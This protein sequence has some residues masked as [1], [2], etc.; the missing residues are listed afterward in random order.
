MGSFAARMMSNPLFS[1]VYEHAWRPVF[2]RGFSL[3]GPET[4]DYDAALRAFLRRPGERIVL[5]IACG[6]GNY[7]RD[8]AAGLTGDGRVVGIDYSPSMLHTAVA[9]NSIT[10]ASYLRV[11]AHAIPFA[12]NTFDEVICLAALYLIPDPLPVLDEMLR[13]ARPGALLVVFTS[14]AGPVSTIPGVTTLATIGGYR[15]F[16]HDEITG[17]LRRGGA[18]HIE[19]SV[20]G[21]GQYVLAWAPGAH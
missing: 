9:T 21:E 2:T 18:E 19:Q 17:A 5:D 10:R 14:V 1:R 12:D 7:T 8:I 16:K 3:G 13:V 20:I 15:V 4:A 11:D 6:P